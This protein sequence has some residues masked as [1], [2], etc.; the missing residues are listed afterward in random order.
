MESDRARRTAEAMRRDGFAALVCRQPEHVLMLTGEYLPILG[1]A[2][3]LVTLGQ[4]GNPEV[5]LAIPKTD[6]DLVP[7]GTARTVKTFAEETMQWIGTTL[8]AARDPLKEILA[9]AGLGPGALV[10]YEGGHKPVATAYTQVGVPGPATLDLLRELLP[11]CRFADA[12]KLLEELA[13]VK[14][15]AELEGI[16]RAERVARAGF[17]AARAA[18]RPGTTEAAIAAAAHAELLRA[19]YAAPGAHH[20]LPFVHVMAGKRAANAA[21]AFN[22]TSNAIVERGD[23]VLVQF[24]IGINGYWAELTRTFFAGEIGEMWKRAYTACYAAQEAALQTIADGVTGHAADA[25]A[26]SVLA[27]EG[28]GEAFKHGLGHGFGLQAIN[29]GAAPILHPALGPGAAHEHGAQHG[30]GGLPGG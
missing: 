8:E 14:T 3:C 16:R 20:V 1:T 22:L 2:F 11:N 6:T 5:R 28:F 24:E 18:V 10:G 15:P 23:P 13:A 19:G 17:E 21:K 9:D 7:D 25:A 30:A 26:R 29:H 4:D 12:S 27:A